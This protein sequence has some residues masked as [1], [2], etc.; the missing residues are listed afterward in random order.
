MDYNWSS[1]LRRGL[2]ARSTSQSRRK[3]RVPEEAEITSDE[4]FKMPRLSQRKVQQIGKINGI[5]NQRGKYGPE[6]S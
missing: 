1:T 3:V 4:E 5:T 2:N 6:G